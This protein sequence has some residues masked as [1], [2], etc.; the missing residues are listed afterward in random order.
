MSLKEIFRAELDFL[1]KDGKYFSKV[2]PHLS[3]FLSDEIIDP[4]AERIIESFAFLT[5]RLKEKIQDSFPEL[6]QS[7]IQLL[8]PNYLRPLPSCAI[9]RFDPKERAITTKHIIPKGTFVNSKPVDG[10]S[11][12]FKITS[13]VAVYPLILRSIDTNV[14]PKSTILEL[15]LGNIS[16]NNFASL[17]CDELSIH[18]SGSDYNALTCYQWLF[19]YLD[20][21]TVQVNNKEIQ[22]PLDCISQQGLEEKDSLL[23][24]PENAFNGYRLIQEF[25]FFPKKFYFF[26]LINL[27]KYLKNIEGDELKLSFRFNRPIPKDLNLGLSDFTLYCSPIINLF[28][29]D[30]IPINLNGKKTAYPVIPV[31]LNKSHFEIFE[32][33][34]VTG[35]KLS[36][37][38][39]KKEQLSVYP[40]FETFSHDI[41]NNRRDTAFYK[42]SLKEN[43][44]ENGYEHYISFVSN[45]NEVQEKN[46]ETISID[47]QCTNRGLPEYLSLGDICIPSQD[48]PSYINFENIT[49]PRSTVR[50]VL[51]GSLH[52]QLISNLSLNYM[53]LNNLDMLKSVLSVYDFSATYDLQ[54]KRRTEKRL[55]A[56]KSISTVPIDR[57]IKGAVYRGVKSIIKIDG[58]KFLCEGEV[59]LFGS[60]LAEFFRLY[61]TINSFHELEII[62]ISNNEIFKWSRKQALQQVI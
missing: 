10:T 1:K 26:K 24:Y 12:S 52:W 34:K 25:F 16:E 37:Y 22:L 60:I 4:E 50:P 40:R 2:H 45:G 53:S 3:R 51:D 59:F 15:N 42:S 23:P 48:T 27:H 58:D 31:G 29:H 13:D 54:S 11:C 39:G 6:T 17:K 55:D 33:E 35:I 5:A 62:N 56:I 44:E 38:T 49:R 18:L 8:W 61:G 28:E 47:L 9:L 46:N 30:A 36:E 41:G 20:K 43:I 19:N 21:I 7:I 14:T 32:I 57:I